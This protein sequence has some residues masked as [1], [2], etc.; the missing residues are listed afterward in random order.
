L[1]GYDAEG[2]EYDLST[3]IVFE[4]NFHGIGPP[5]EDYY[6]LLYIAPDY[7]ENM[8]FQD[9]SVVFTLTAEM[10]S[11]DVT[12]WDFWGVLGDDETEVDFRIAMDDAPWDSVAE[13][14]GEGGTCDLGGGGSGVPSCLTISPTDAGPGDEVTLTAFDENGEWY[15]FRSQEGVELCFGDAGCVWSGGEGDEAL[16]V[17]SGDGVFTITQ[18]Q[19]DSDIF[20]FWCWPDEVWFT[21]A[22]PY[23]PSPFDT[24]A[25]AI[26]AGG[27]CE[28]PL[29][30]S[31]PALDIDG[32]CRVGMYEL[33]ALFDA[34]LDPKDFFDFAELANHW[35]DCGLD[36]PSACW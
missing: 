8:A 11:E 3:M 5:G 34:W 35:L 12:V 9:G 14:I 10:L 31:P 7:F 24:V 20:D 21:L 27:N 18:A 26:A 25:E 29:C 19:L 28:G 13:A 1:T 30:V 22:N 6:T 2:E 15:D 17:S 36:P 23:E 33:I 4:S 32:D 16:D